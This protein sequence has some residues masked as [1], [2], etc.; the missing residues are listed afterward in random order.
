M[1]EFK[2]L[3]RE[4]EQARIRA[5]D[6]KIEVINLGTEQELKDIKVGNELP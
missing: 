3:A 2:E 6:E 5:V 4:H 1:R